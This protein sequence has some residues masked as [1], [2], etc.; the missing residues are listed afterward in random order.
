MS[1]WKEV[2]KDLVAEQP[3]L[4][5]SFIGLFLALFVGL[6]IRAAIAPERVQAHLKE[7]T[8]T[9]HKDLHFQFQ[10]AYVRLSNGFWPDLSVVVENVRI[11]SSKTCWLMPLV[12]IN[13]IRLPLSWRHLFRGQ[14]LIHEILADEVNLSLRSEFQQCGPQKSPASETDSVTAPKAAAKSPAQ[15]QVMGELENVSRDNPIDT[16]AISSLKIHYLPLPFTT[17]YIDRFKAKLQAEEPKKVQIIGKLNLEGDSLGK[18]FGSFANLQIDLQEGE[19]PQINALVRGLWREGQY[20]LLAKTD[21]KTQSFSLE[22]D[23]KQLPLSRVIPI[24]KKYRWIESEFNG[25][26]SWISAKIRS[27]GKISALQSTPVVISGLKLE[28]DLGEITSKQIEIQSF[29][30]LKFKPIDFQIHGLNI[31]EL[32]VFLNRPHPSPALGD[33]GLFNGSAHFISP[34]RLQMRGD[35]S[36]L[37]FIFSNRGTRQVQT[38]S[39]VSGELELNKNHWQIDIDRIRPVEGIFDGKVKMRADKDFR[40]LKLEASMTELGLAPR[41]QTLMTGGGSLGAL[42]GQLKVQLKNAQITNLIGQLRSSQMLIE[43][44]RIYRPKAQLQTEN[45]V[46]KIEIS[47]Q[48]AEIFQNSLASNFM[49]P[50]LQ[51]E[52]QQN[53]LLRNPQVILRTRKF[54][55]LSWSQF[56]AQGPTGRINSSGQWNEQAIM[57]GWIQLRG[58]KDKSWEIQGTRNQPIFVP[59]NL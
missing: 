38:L 11:E 56:Q 14:I 15:P 59:K 21:L 48:E 6:A 45:A 50:V 28:G 57:S 13:Q 9:I 43:G 12:E 25:H 54:A 16:V 22:S 33:L 42:S 34:D 18:E 44:V 8:Q 53:L 2:D 39:L 3:G 5:L 29:Q 23:L 58:P 47:A 20:Q 7:A 35:Y 10:K 4:G 30:P 46:F 31:R 49:A 52:P 19:N 51:A 55:S 32:L 17:F 27:E 40:D 1:S 36:G 24:L 37:E 26:R 41:V